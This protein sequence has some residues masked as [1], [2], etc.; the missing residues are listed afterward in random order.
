MKRKAKILIV[1]DDP[2]VL[3]SAKMILKHEFSSID[4][5]ENPTEIPGKISTADYDVILLD[6][7][8]RKGLND[9]KEGFYWLARIREYDPLAV[10]VLITAYGEVDLAVR[11]IKE[12]ASDFVLKPWKNQK[13]LATIHSA[14]ELRQ[15]RRTTDKLSKTNKLYQDKI[16]SHLEFIGES[17][18]ILKVKELIKKVAETDANVLILGE[19]GTGKELVARSIHYHSARAKEAFVQV[20]MGALSPQLFESELFGHLKGSFTDAR[21]DKTGRIEIANG[22]SLFL[23]EIGN[24]REEQQRKLLSVL[25][26]R[27]IIPVGANKTIS[28]DFRL[29]TATNEDI[30]T[31][32]QQHEFRE[33]LLYRINTV[34]I[35]LPPLRDRPEDIPLLVQF[36]LRKYSEKYKKTA[37]KVDDAVLG[38]LSNYDWPGN[39]REL[40]HSVERAVILSSGETL[41][42]SADFIARHQQVKSASY[43]LNK[44]LE[45]VEKQHIIAV[46]ASHGGNVT[47][48]AQSL[49]LTRTAMYRRLNKY[50]LNG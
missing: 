34:E 38:E 49:G 26:Q 32:V 7:N 25:Q 21:E 1:D 22:G 15:S 43:E 11:A 20:D 4:L 47:K 37:A 39:I 3:E 48:A 46:L 42:N 10:V 23:D 8:F 50:D 27:K 19:N 12:G 2:D 30:Y 33:D 14:L 41:E 24:I 44:T 31:R 6:M 40:Q 45:D 28:V 13:L 17:P 5:L 29:I 35:N 36:F 9:G 18:A 16:F